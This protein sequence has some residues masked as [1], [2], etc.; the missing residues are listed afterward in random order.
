MFFSAFLDR[1]SYGVQN[2]LIGK[3]YGVGELGIYN[4]A[5]ATCNVPQSII[6]TVVSRVLFPV[7]S[8]ASRESATERG[9]ST[10]VGRWLGHSLRAAMLINAPVMLGMLATADLAVRVVLGG[11]WLAAIPILRVLCLSGLFWP[12]HII[13]LTVLSSVGRSDL[14]FRVEVMKKAVWIPM[15]AAA[16]WLGVIWI[17]WFQVALTLIAC[18]VT[19]WDSYKLVRYRPSEQLKDFAPSVA[20]ASLMAAVVWLISKSLSTS[21]E[22]KLAICIVRGCLT[23]VSSCML[24]RLRAAQEAVAL[25]R[26]LF[27]RWPR[28]VPKGGQA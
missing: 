27:P 26:S 6:S 9:P 3:L 24:L 20:T 21:P 5:E 7:F 15:L 13:N 18:V 19:I 12:I 23:Y 10:T 28:P 11:R 2:L 1:A 17:A 4:R 14:F 16:S 22:L 25:A 8:S